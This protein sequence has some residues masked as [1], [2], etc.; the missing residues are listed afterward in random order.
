MGPSPPQTEQMPI[1]NPRITVGY[2][3]EVIISTTT[4]DDDIPIFPIQYSPKVT[5]ESKIK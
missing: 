5:T 2:N 1:P 4:K 3:S